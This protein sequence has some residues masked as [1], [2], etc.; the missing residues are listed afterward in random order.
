MVAKVDS[1]TITI[2]NHS[3]VHKLTETLKG[4]EYP[5]T[6]TFKAGEDSRSNRQNRLSFRWYKDAE[7]QGDMTA[8]E[9]RAYC[10]AYFGVSILVAENDDFAIQYNELI[11]PLP[12]ED[13]MALMNPPIDLP[14]TSLM[15]VKQMS[16]YLNDV[17]DHFTGLGFTLTDPQ[18]M[19]LEQG[20]Y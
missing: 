10:K 5:Y 15:T 2:R 8:Q 17:W 11:R 12:Y 18:L 14:V 1:L 20:R 19:G 3:D 13:K 9:Y 7:K 6:L 4:R 16:R